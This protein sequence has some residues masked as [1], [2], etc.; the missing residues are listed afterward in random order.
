MRFILS[1]C[2]VH[3]KLNLWEYSAQILYIDI[4]ELRVGSLQ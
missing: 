4:G 1:T 2:D 3:F